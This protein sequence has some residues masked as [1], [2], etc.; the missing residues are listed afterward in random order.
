MVGGGWKRPHS[1]RVG[2]L[3]VF[4]YWANAPDAENSSSVL[5]TAVFITN[6]ALV[7][8]VSENSDMESCG[9]PL[10]PVTLS[11]CLCV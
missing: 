2:H 4:R 10:Q 1:L 7:Q 5:E 3:D 9:I 8:I 6:D 11:W